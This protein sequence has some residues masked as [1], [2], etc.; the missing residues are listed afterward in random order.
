MSQQYSTPTAAQTRS[1]ETGSDSVAPSI[2]IAGQENLQPT[3]TRYFGGE[4][5]NLGEV[6]AL[7]Q[8]T[9]DE[10]VE[11]VIRKPVPMPLSQQ[12]LLAL[13]P[14]QANNRKRVR[15][16][17]P[18]VFAESPSK[19]QASIARSC[20][21]VFID[22][23]DPSDASRVLGSK[24]GELLGDL[25]AVIHHTARSTLAEPRLR[26]II[27]ADSVPAQRYGDAVLELGQKLGI[28][29]TRESLVP[30]QPMYL[31]C[32]F[33]DVARNP[34]VYENPFGRPYTI[35]NAPSGINSA[36]SVEDHEPVAGGLEH[37]RSRV[38][39]VTPELAKEDLAGLDPDCSM[40]D[41]IETGMGLKHQ[42]GE[43]GWPLWD[44][45]SAKGKKYSGEAS[46]RKRWDSFVAHPTGRAPVTY[47]TIQSK[48]HSSWKVPIP[49]ELPAPPAL[50]LATAIPR[51]LGQFRS[52][53]EQT[54]MALQVS[55][56]AIAPLCLGI[57]SGAAGR[58]YEVRI[59]ADWCETAVLWV[60][61]LA[62][63][64]ERKS[65]LIRRLT[66]PLSAWQSD[67]HINHSA[68]LTTYRTE[69][70]QLQA[71]L[72][73]LLKKISQP[74]ATNPA[75]LQQQS[76]S[77]AQSLA[78]MPE[79]HIPEILAADATPEALR[80]LL[81]QNG[82]KAILVSAETD[83]QQLTGSRYSKDGAQ[84]LNLMLAG[85]SGD[86]LA[87]HRVTKSEPLQR[88]AIALVMFV[89]PTAMS[90]VL[91]DSNTNGR[92]F[93]QRFMIIQ[94]RSLMGQRN[95]T[96]PSV[97]KNLVSWWDS[98]V[99]SILDA[100]WP[101]R[102]M[103]VQGKLTKSTTPTR[104]LTLDGGASAELLSLR[105]DIELR[106][107]PDEDLRSIS[108]FASKLPGEI[109]RISLAFELMNNPDAPQ[110]S[111]SSMAAACQ[112]RDF[113]IAHHQHALGSAAETPAR[114]HARRLIASLAQKHVT[115]LSARE[116]LRRIQ[117]TT[118]MTSMSELSPVL[119]ELVSHHYL[120]P[121]PRP[122]TRGRGHPPS[123]IYEV[124]PAIAAS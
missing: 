42:F 118:D 3:T 69:R 109:V 56:D 87:N 14:Q 114:R 124:N 8:R 50:D 16:L 68:A 21:L 63:P 49:L 108:G 122:E 17:V 7:P 73:G 54:A 123:V 64:G 80:A 28:K 82:E 112:W 47:R 65:A 57:I 88:P 86:A 37:L 101:G 104:E 39:G 120:R 20:N 103:Q 116:C 72:D 113:L 58:S 78:A 106:L 38:E 105:K 23:D 92:G 51:N 53:V 9:F 67:E 66:R 12:E 97:C 46:T 24:T 5:S 41:W 2:P 25:G 121:L 93:V 81:Y 70:K 32:S 26:V 55:E 77:V 43:T 74:N 94:A 115:A 18:A 59:N 62:E 71:K 102:V 98:T 110:I 31:P 40:H 10:L 79:L 52:F 85:K 107:R 48:V 4:P 95:L 60:A 35:P 44:E 76:Q 19:R 29:P 84:N 117:N 33:P 1:V 89:Q 36:E 30:V 15:Y 111:T 100:P 34:I 91:R 119:H 75:Q 83:F 27:N 6:Q 96:P 61:A 90:D 13:P 22:I 99:R 11:Q 45:W